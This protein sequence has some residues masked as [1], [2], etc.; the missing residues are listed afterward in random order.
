MKLFAASDL[1]IDFSANREK[2][3]Q[4]PARPD[5][6]LV[7]AG[8]ISH[9]VPDMI[10]A[11]DHLSSRWK[12]V[13]WAPGNHDLWTA[14]HEGKRYRGVEKY[15]LLVELCREREVLTPEDPYPILDLDGQDHMLAPLLT[16]YDYSFRP[17]NIPEEMAVF[18]ALQSNVM[19]TDEYYL[20]PH[21]YQTRVAWCADRCRDTEARLLGAPREIPLIL[22]GHFPLREDLIRIKIPRFNIWCGTRLTEQWHTRFN[23]SMVIGG[24]LHTPGTRVRN[25]VPFHEVS[26][27]YPRQWSKRRDLKFPRDVTPKAKEWTHPLPVVKD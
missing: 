18:W 24:H 26:L 20:H 7:L 16:L 21:P 27:G 1:H 2:V 15:E 6:W 13:S 19:S 25:Q 3:E 22:V 9:K 5:D 11:L 14:K 17:D 10:W 4:L 23:V 12:G 8:D